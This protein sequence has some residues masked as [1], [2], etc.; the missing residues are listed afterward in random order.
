MHYEGLDYDSPAALQDFLKTLNI[1]PRKF[2]GQNFLINRGVREKIIALLDLEKDDELWEIGAGLGAMTA[3]AV[4]KTASLRVFEIDYAYQRILENFFGEH[5]SFSLVAGDVLKTFKM[6]KTDKAVKI[7]GN[8]P[9]NI[10]SAVIQ[11]FPLQPF[12]TAV[13]LVQKELGSR[14]TAMPRAKNY[15]SFSVWSQCR[16]QIKSHGIVRPHSFYPV[17]RV[18]SVIISLR[19]ANQMPEKF[20]A[21]LENLVR[22]AFAGRR[23]TLRNNF[24]RAKENRLKHIPQDKL[25]DAC[26]HA[27]MDLQKRAEEYAPDIYLKCAAYLAEEDSAL[28]V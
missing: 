5:P 10:A 11:D 22:S 24:E 20:S 18:D 6:Q 25:F 13:L 27:G 28:S 4:G 15:S 3:L 17:P 8:L 14:M 19:P 7:L 2:L 16:F 23:K 26:R 12:K 1:S 9:Y 21:I